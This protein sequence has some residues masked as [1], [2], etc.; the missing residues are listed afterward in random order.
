MKFGIFKLKAINRYHVI[1]KTSN[2]VQPTHSYNANI[3]KFKSG[4]VITIMTVFD[5][6]VGSTNMENE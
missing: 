6:K 3:P 2:K 5:E 4:T 1:F